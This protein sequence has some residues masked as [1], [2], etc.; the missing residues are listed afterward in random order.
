MCV[1][2]KCTKSYLLNILYLY[3]FI[4]FQ[5]LKF[6]HVTC[7]ICKLPATQATVD[8]CFFFEYVL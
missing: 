3:V 6:L 2:R 4:N 7:Y 8:F 5:I 1:Y